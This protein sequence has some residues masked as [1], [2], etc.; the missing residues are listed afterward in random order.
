M[1][2]NQLAERRRLSKAGELPT[3]KAFQEAEARLLEIAE[4]FWER[5]NETVEGIDEI[6]RTFPH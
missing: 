5:Y 1:N 3:S 2:N 4:Q 6:W